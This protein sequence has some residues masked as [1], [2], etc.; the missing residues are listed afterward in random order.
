MCYESALGL[1][2]SLLSNPLKYF[3]CKA[4]KEVEIMA[5]GTQIESETKTAKPHTH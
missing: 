3:A 2:H 5:P 4:I 1:A